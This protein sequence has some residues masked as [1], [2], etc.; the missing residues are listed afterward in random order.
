MCKLD[1]KVRF[2][3]NF[4]VGTL[5]VDKPGKIVLLIFEVL[6]KAKLF[7]SIPKL[8]T[9]LFDKSIFLLLP[10]FVQYKIMFLFLSNAICYGKI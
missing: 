5:L 4:I 1:V 3:E 10:D 9:K 7:T 8:V 6:E 2:I